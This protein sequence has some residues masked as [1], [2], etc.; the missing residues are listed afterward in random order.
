VSEKHAGFIVKA[1]EATAADILALI[2]IVQAEVEA[3]FGVRLETEV[4]IL[5]EDAACLEG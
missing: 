1:G 3:R 2:A 4:R 5:G